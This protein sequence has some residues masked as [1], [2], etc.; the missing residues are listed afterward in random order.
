MIDPILEFDWTPVAA[1]ILI[2]AAILSALRGVKVFHHVDVGPRAYRGR[3]EPDDL[4]SQTDDFFRGRYESAE[5]VAYA[6][7]HVCFP[8]EKGAADVEIPAPRTM[9]VSS[10]VSPN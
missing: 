7:H 5:R 2:V 1:I 6:V 8:K 4:F 10:S 3:P 9:E